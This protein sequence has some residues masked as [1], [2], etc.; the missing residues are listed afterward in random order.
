ME[1]GLL[2]YTGYSGH[3]YKDYKTLQDKTTL[4]IEQYGEPMGDRFSPRVTETVLT[5]EVSRNKNN[6]EDR[7]YIGPNCDEMLFCDHGKR[8]QKLL[9]PPIR[10][11]IGQEAGLVYI[12]NNRNKTIYAPELEF[13]SA[14]T[15]KF[16][17]KDSPIRN[18]KFYEMS[19]SLHTTIQHSMTVIREGRH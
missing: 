12:E 3:Y 6:K 1:T 10:Q 14:C 15:M 7:N 19:G 2:W 18:P 11:V 8:I 5:H 16:L 13:S 4:T 17:R 9:K